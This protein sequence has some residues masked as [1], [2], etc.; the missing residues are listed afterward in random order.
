MSVAAVLRVSNCFCSMLVCYLPLQ[1]Q[2]DVSARCCCPPLQSQP[3]SRLNAVAR[4]DYTR[5]LRVWLDQL[6]LMQAAV[7]QFVLSVNSYTL[8]LVAS[9]DCNLLT[10]SDCT[11]GLCGSVGLAARTACFGCWLR[12]WGRRLLHGSR[13][14]CDSARH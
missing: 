10:I 3:M 13:A 14:W 6:C 1:S 7:H 8:S 5:Q 11:A 4:S 9:C 12:H 2:L